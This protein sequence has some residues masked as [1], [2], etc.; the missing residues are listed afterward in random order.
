MFYPTQSAPP[1]TAPPLL[2]GLGSVW[3]LPEEHSIV[4]ISGRLEVKPQEE[5]GSRRRNGSENPE[6]RP[7]PRGM[8]KERTTETFALRAMN[9]WKPSVAPRRP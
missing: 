2:R 3:P 8:A 7:R 6:G 1:H 4:A 9:P 5:A